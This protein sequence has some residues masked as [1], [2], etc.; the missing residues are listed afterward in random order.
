MFI[1]F[2][3]PSPGPWQACCAALLVFLSAAATHAQVAQT[4]TL[5]AALGFTEVAVI[6]SRLRFAGDAADSTS[7]RLWGIPASATVDYHN[8]PQIGP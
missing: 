5:A 6:R 2:K 7:A 4:P 1:H 8:P 3:F